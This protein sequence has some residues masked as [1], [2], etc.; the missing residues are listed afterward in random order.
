M[1]GTNNVNSI[2]YGSR[3]LSEA[4]GD[5][6]KVIKYL[7][8]VFPSSMINL[9]NILPMYKLGRYDVVR[10][11]NF[12]VKK[13]CLEEMINVMETEH[14]FNFKNGLR[15][16]ELFVPPSA[17]IADNCHLNRTRVTKLGRHLKYWAHKHIS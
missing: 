6:I 3:S 12:N 9:V 2:Y 5:I 15:R 4:V 1:C 14:L 10:E 16:N 17:Q 13:F 7:K 11:I 8:T